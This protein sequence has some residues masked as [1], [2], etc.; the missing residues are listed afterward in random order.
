MYTQEE[1]NARGCDYTRVIRPSLEVGSRV[2]IDS[3]LGTGTVV[4][5][6]D[7]DTVDGSLNVEEDWVI[8]AL[9]NG[10]WA[11]KGDS[12]RTQGAAGVAYCSV[13][14]VSISNLEV[15]D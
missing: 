3:N 6:V 7:K 2:E 12:W 8:V 13:L 4:A 1:M 5:W 15:I 11:W 10:L 9:D 14:V